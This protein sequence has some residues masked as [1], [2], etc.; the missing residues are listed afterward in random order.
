[1]A[2]INLRRFPYLQSACLVAMAAAGPAAADELAPRASWYDR[3]VQRLESTWRE[4]QPELYLP[5]Y[6]YHLP[7][8]YTREKIKT[9]DADNV[10]MNEVLGPVD[11]DKNGLNLMTCAGTVKKGTSDFTQRLVVF[12]SQVD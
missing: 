6:T 12:T 7:F 1:M 5:L 10:D 2:K 4:G 11:A 9:Y 3:T 8:A